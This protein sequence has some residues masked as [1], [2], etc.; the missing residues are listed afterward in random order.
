MQNKL[1]LS[2]SKMSAEMTKNFRKLLF[3]TV[4]IL[5]DKNFSQEIGVKTEIFCMNP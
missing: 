3:L 2:G 1:I 4:F 5:F